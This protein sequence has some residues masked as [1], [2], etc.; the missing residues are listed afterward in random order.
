MNRLLIHAA[1]LCLLASIPAGAVHAQGY[2][3]LR[4]DF[5]TYAPPPF[6]ESNLLRR[7]IGEE[8]PRDDGRLAAPAADRGG[9]TKGD[10]LRRDATI[11]ADAG[12][13]YI[14]P[15]PALIDRLKPAADS[16]D[17]ASG[18][19]RGRFSLETLEV[20]VLLRHPG[21][22]AQEDRLRAALEGYD[23]VAQVDEILRRYSA[24]TEGLMT[25]IGPMKGRDPVRMKFPFPGVRALRGR[26]VDREVA[27]AR[28]EL[29]RVGRETVTEARRTYWDLL[30]VRKARPVTSETLDL[31]RRL[32]T[33]ADTRYKSG[34]ASYQDAIKARIQREILEEKLV[35][36]GEREKNLKTKIRELV[37]LPAEAEVGSPEDRAP[38]GRIP[39]LAEL[40]AL[41][42]E[43]RQELL[44]MRETI[45]KMA[46]MV[47]MAET[48]ILPAFSPGYSTHED[49]PVGTAGT[50]AMKEAF[51]TTITAQRGA[52]LPKMAW[53]G[54][55]DAFLRETRRRLSALEMEL[56]KSEAATRTLVRN[57]WFRL[58]EAKR[59]TRLYEN[60]LLSLSKSALDV[61]NRGYESGMVSFVDAIGSY[62]N[63]LEVNLTHQ[64]KRSDTGIA[65]AELARVVG[66]DPWGQ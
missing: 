56:E 36:L 6:Y 18:R 65:M 51:P 55:Q 59:Q 60:T 37:N 16:A 20:L 29:S 41:A 21:I 62:T 8:A 33:V 14:R 5:E 22:A 52:G 53:Y 10:G 63:W 31:F 44:R 23:Q 49:E 27:A 4:E 54:T 13:R 38:R 43:N 47:E 11:D 24:F 64:R 12:E 46:A 25:G 19:L 26:I 30:Y 3:S 48:M 32:E 9:D 34:S 2:G 39:G 58:D 35:T 45:G 1:L 66:V 17:E 50:A 40:Q 7:D 42:L 28:A 15:D 57:A 61:S